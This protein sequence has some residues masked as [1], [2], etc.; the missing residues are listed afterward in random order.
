MRFGVVSM[1]AALSADSLMP[2]SDPGLPEPPFTRGNRLKRMK[3]GSHRCESCDRT[4]SANKRQ[5]F[6]C[7]E[8]AR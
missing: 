7:K 1:L 3:G 4:I 6:A 5:C 8:S 2:R